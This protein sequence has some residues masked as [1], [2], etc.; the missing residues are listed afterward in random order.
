MMEPLLL[1]VA[2]VST[3]DGERALTAAT[4]FFFERGERLFL[5]TGR[6]VLIDVPTAHRPDRVEITVHT[7][8]VDLT[9]SAVV[10]LWLYR[11]GKSAWRQAEDSGGEIDVAAIELPRDTLPEGIVLRA[12]TLAHLES[13]LEEVGIGT[14]ALVV[15]F[16]LGFYDTLHN[17]PVARQASVASAFGVRFQGQGYFLTDARMHRGAS[18]APVVL[19]HPGGDPVLPWKLLGI[20]SARLDMR[21]RE[22]GVDESLGLN[23]AWYADI[24]RT[25]TA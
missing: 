24:L 7:D 13:A 17:L 3:F 12:F 20:H 5:V 9:R 14:A 11:D 1:S 15:G 19:Q 18:G 10:S 8:A 2:R 6:H 22:Q 16:P 23:C 21:T 25:L 4:G